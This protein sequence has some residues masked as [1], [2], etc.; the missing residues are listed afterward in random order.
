MKGDLEQL[1]REVNQYSLIIAGHRFVKASEMRPCKYM[2]RNEIKNHYGLDK[3]DFTKVY[4]VV[5]GR[6]SLT[7]L[8][9]HFHGEM[10]HRYNLDEVSKPNLQQWNTPK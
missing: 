10:K 6:S 5:R 1:I 8:S 7:D 2:M 3:G 4:S 9:K